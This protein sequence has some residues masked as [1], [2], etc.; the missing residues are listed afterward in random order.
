MPTQTPELE[1]AS[2]EDFSFSASKKRQGQNFD[3]KGR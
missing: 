3:G 1:P 2:E